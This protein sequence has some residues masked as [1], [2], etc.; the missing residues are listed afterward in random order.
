MIR[1]Y[2][3]MIGMVFLALCFTSSCSTG[4]Q[5]Q[6]KEAERD[7]SGAYNGYWEGVVS[8]TPKVQYG[9]GQWKHNCAD[10]SNE[11]V[12][13]VKVKDGKM[14]GFLY[15]QSYFVKAY[16]N[17]KGEFR[18]ENPIGNVRAK[19]AATSAKTI[20]RDSITLIVRGSLDDKTAALTFG[21]EELGNNGCT[22]SVKMVRISDE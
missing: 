8:N 18:I 12:L 11:N 1:Y 7:L 21:I 22:S 2:V 17:D 5:S 6:V 9:P 14:T 20:N 3:S 10:R 16:V 4:L 19:T 13:G 15:G